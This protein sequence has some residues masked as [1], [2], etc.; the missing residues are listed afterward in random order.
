MSVQML[1]NVYMRDVILNSVC[2]L[3]CLWAIAQACLAG[4][5]DFCTV[6]YLS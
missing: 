6:C 5:H 1:L 2:F 4:W 3:L